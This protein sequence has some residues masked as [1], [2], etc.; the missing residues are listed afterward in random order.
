MNGYVLPVVRKEGTR[1]RKGQY[2]ERRA[3]VDAAA[4]YVVGCES[5]DFF[6]LGVNEGRGR[7]A[8]WTSRVRQ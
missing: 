4:G 2:P 6:L 8:D 3:K 1:W 5:T 7:G